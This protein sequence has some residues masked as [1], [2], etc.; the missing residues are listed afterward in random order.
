MFFNKSLNAQ[1]LAVLKI[2]HRFKAPQRNPLKLPSTLSASA[3]GGRRYC[4]FA[5]T[6]QP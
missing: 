2:N 5:T 4:G 6:A 1:N 3:A